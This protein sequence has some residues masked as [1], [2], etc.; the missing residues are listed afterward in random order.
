M[1]KLSINH[2]ML[3][4]RLIRRMDKRFIRAKHYFYF[5]FQLITDQI[6]ENTPIIPTSRPSHKIEMTDVHHAAGIYNF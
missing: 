1:G 6:Y 4:K 3:T 5:T 2:E